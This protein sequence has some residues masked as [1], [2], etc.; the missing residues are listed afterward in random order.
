[1]KQL[2][3]GRTDIVVPDLCLGT[4]TYGTHTLDD[5]AH[6]Q[7]EICLD[8]GINFVDVA[9]MYPVN[10][11]KAETAG[12]SEEVIGRWFAKTGRR[13]DVI[14]ATKI[15][16]AGGVL[17]SGEGYNART[18]REAFDASLR[19]L[20]TDYIDLYQL[21]WPNRGSYHFRQN[22]GFNP[23][24]QNTQKALDNMAET[25]EVAAALVKEG[26]LRAFGLSNESAWGTMQWLR[27]A[28]ELNAPRVASIQNE[29]SLLARMYD[30]DMG[31]LAVHE[32]VTLLSYSPLGCGLLTGKYQNGQVPDGSRLAINGDLGGRKTD[33]VFP[34]V[35]AY[36]A[37]A[38][39]HGLDLVAMSLAWQRHR[40]FPI[41]AIFGATR[42][43]QLDRILKA[44]DLTLDEEVL[45]DIDAA[46][47]KH[48]MPF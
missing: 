24:K 25:I 27:L 45:A 30:T 3:L 47:R 22:W 1:M 23:A 8:A 34:A 9:E 20:Q 19:R 28:K 42:V 15:A 46:H 43:E 12:M 37:V 17:R 6:R 26:K 44:V 36:Q 5:D 14:L 16:G 2:P 41:S 32:D 31:E 18:M 4:M 35:D 48:P 40:P 21:H 11:V 13:K 10:P 33:R 38:D 7:I 29:Y 39:K